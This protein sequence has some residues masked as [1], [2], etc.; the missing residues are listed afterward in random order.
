MTIKFV[1]KPYHTD[2]VNNGYKPEVMKTFCAFSNQVWDHI[3]YRKVVSMSCV[4]A[5]TK[6]GCG[7]I[8]SLATACILPWCCNAFTQEMFAAPLDGYIEENLY[9]HNPELSKEWADKDYKD[10][11]LD[12][13]NPKSIKACFDKNI[14]KVRSDYGHEYILLRG[15]KTNC[16]YIIFLPYSNRKTEDNIS[17]H[18]LYDA[19]YGNELDNTRLLMTAKAFCATHKSTNPIHREI[20]RDETLT[21]TLLSH[22]YS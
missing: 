5:T 20:T 8:W 16:S 10:F 4:E 6:V 21:Y 2:L 17:I 13:T 15:I 19:T 12:P 3:R 11:G 14:D 22:I 9:V 7:I 1:E 18:C